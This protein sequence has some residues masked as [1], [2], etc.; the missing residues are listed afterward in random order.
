[1]KFV[2][3]T[4]SSRD[5][6]YESNENKIYRNIS[7]QFLIFINIYHGIK[8]VTITTY[9]IIFQKWEIG[10]YLIVNYDWANIWFFVIMHNKY[11]LTVTLNEM[12]GLKKLPH[13]IRNDKC[14]CNVSNLLIYS[15][16]FK[17]RLTQF[18]YICITM[19]L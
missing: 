18:S 4:T 13:C 14:L 1:M 5:I 17:N 15:S 19:Y 9:S 11:T 6:L 12:N 10:N 2:A 8:F 3:K 7:F 16:K